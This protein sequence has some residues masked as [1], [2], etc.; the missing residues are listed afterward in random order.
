M[1]KTVE[2][3]QKQKKE[4]IEGLKFVA[5]IDLATGKVEHKVSVVLPVPKSAADEGEGGS[6]R[7]KKGKKEKKDKKEKK[8]K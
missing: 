2:E 8:E 5:N 4:W 1:D 7:K 6:K 3:E